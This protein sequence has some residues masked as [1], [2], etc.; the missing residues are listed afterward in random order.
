MILLS[1]SRVIPWAMILVSCAM[2]AIV[3]ILHDLTGGR[4]SIPMSEV[5]IFAVPVGFL[6]TWRTTV[7]HGRWWE[8][9]HAWRDI[10]SLTV[11]MSLQA[12][13][14]SKGQLQRDAARRVVRTAAAA[15]FALRNA[16]QTQEALS[17]EDPHTRWAS[18]LLGVSQ[19]VAGND[20]IL[21]AVRHVRSAVRDFRLAYPE[22]PPSI[23][24]AMDSHA[25]GILKAAKSIQILQQEPMP[26]SFV[27]LLRTILVLYLGIVP[28]LSVGV[29]SYVGVVIFQ[30]LISFALMCVEASAEELEHP[31]DAV[32]VNDVEVN[33]IALRVGKALASLEEQVIDN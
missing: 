6:L 7:S 25:S 21:L 24:G 27:V 33:R 10:E 4:M 2:A 1:P 20:S 32:D 16:V 18:K 30:F 19:D 28:F 5:T 3:C 11:D 23:I 9:I 26:E 15:V 29:L 14:W 31:C 8:G 22:V 13:E 17:T 12:V